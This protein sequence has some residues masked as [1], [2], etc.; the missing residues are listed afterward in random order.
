M[1]VTWPAKAPN[2]AIRYT[3]T[4]PLQDDDTLSSFSSSVSGAVIDDEDYEGSDVI[5]Y[6]SGGSP[7]TTA[8]FTLT[9]FTGNGETIEETIYLPIIGN[10][11][12]LAQTAQDVV[13]FALRPIVG[14]FRDPT[15][16]QRADALEWLNGLLAEWRAQGADTGATLP[17]TLTTPLSIPDEYILGIKAALR[18]LASEQYG[19]QV[20]QSTMLQAARGLQLV[21]N[22]NIPDEREQAVYY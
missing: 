4:V 14:L 1:A 19:R 9:A 11:A 7:G 21:K 3:W 2:S 5:I 12:V 10:T 8:A 18:T 13:D 17:L 22:A 6:V 16:D 20:S 15:D